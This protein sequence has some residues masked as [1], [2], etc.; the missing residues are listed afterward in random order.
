M[1][2]VTIDQIKD[3]RNK[4]GISMMECKNALAETDGNLEKAMDLLRKKG[5]K[6]AAKR[7]ASEAKEGIIHAY[8]HPGS[9]VGVLL[10]VNC[11]TDFSAKT[12]ILKQFAHDICMQIAAGRPLCINKD[13]LDPKIVDK[14]LDIIKEELKTS[15]K[16]EHLIEK[17][18]E[19]K[20]GKFYE[21][22]CLLNQ[23]FIKNDKLTIQDY[24]NEL[25][26]KIGENIQ[27]KKFT[28]Y[29]LGK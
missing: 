3:L 10:E 20:L 26:A 13:E 7:S 28:L 22:A 17:I 1:A 9:K 25:I 2:K 6:I 4:T 11:E 16:P 27:I 15:G 8:I 14:E 12:D 24:L 18:A 19:N 21:S 23:S 29:Q 5:A